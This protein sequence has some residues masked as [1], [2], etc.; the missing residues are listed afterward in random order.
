MS[1]TVTH[2]PYVS[3]T[4]TYQHV[5]L[6]C[7]NLYQCMSPTV[8]NYV[9]AAVVYNSIRKFGDLGLGLGLGLGL[10]LGL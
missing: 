6:I 10:E 7:R 9:A 1:P 3:P 2:L 8:T 4:V 5:T